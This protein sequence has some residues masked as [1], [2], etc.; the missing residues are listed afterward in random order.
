GWFNNDFRDFD[1]TEDFIDDT[2]DFNDR[3][4]GFNRMPMFGGQRGWFFFP[5]IPIGIG[6][7]AIIIVVALIVS[8]K[9]NTAAPENRAK[10]LLDLRYARGEIS[11]E[12]YLRAKEVLKDQ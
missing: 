12:E 5:W 3:Q 4:D 6:I 11:E 2:E 1:D 9:R 7:V 8:N 10:E